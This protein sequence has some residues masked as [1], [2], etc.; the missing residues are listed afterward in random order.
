MA[1]WDEIQQ[2]TDI[3]S[4]APAGVA[5]E[6]LAS[7]ARGEVFRPLCRQFNVTAEGTTFNI[8]NTKAISFAAV[9]EGTAPAEANFDP[10]SVLCTPLLYGV[11]IIVGL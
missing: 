11:D 2:Y 1:R 5:T 7:S 6:A 10:L 9:T 8:P 3:G 4:I